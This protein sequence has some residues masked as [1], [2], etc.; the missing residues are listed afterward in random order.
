MRELAQRTNS[1][2]SIRGTYQE[3]ENGDNTEVK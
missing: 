1:I 2:K 3:D